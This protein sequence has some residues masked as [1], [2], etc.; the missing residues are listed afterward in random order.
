MG[1]SHHAR[2]ESPSA[3]Q[4]AAAEMDGAE[5][6]EAPAVLTLPLRVQQLFPT[7]NPRPSARCLAANRTEAQPPRVSSGVPLIHGS[8]T[9]S[10]SQTNSLWHPLTPISL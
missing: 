3:R 5:G 7:A 1:S 9:R 8:R 4:A 2:K 10:A 6:L